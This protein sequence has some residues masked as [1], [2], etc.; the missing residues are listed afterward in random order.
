[1]RVVTYVLIHGG[2][3]GSWCWDKVV[4]LLLRE[5]HLVEAPDLPGHGKDQTPFQEVTL[6]SCVDKICNIVNA[7]SESVILVG[8]SLGGIVISQVA[9]QIPDKI[10]SLV[11]LTADLLRDGESM[12][13][14]LESFRPLLNISQD[15]SNFT[16]KSDVVAD[17]FYSDCSADDVALAKGL[18][19][20]EAMAIFKTPVRLSNEKFGRVPRI[21]IECLLDQTISPRDQ[22]AMYTA[23]PCLRVISLNTGHSPFLSAPEQLAT[24]LLSLAE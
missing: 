10:R 24:C 19:G 1:M 5:G 11:Y 3:H 2:L 21:Y 17:L 13:S 15:Q 16:I 12:A 9:E 4:P 18:L 7:H 23:T 6:Q 22:K 8:H 20:P 14:R